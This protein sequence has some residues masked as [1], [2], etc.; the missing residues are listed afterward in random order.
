MNFVDTK[1]V[2]YALVA[3]AFTD[4]AMEPQR[5]VNPGVLATARQ[6]A[7]EAA[8]GRGT[9]ENYLALLPRELHTE[10]TGFVNQEL[11]G[12][13]PTEL[14]I[15]V[16]EYLNGKIVQDLSKEEKK[17]LIRFIIHSFPRSGNFIPT[18]IV[19]SHILQ[20]ENFKELANDPDEIKK[21]HDIINQYQRGRGS[22]EN[23]YVIFALLNTEGAF[24]YLKN[25]YF[26]NSSQKWDM[27]REL[28]E[29]MKSWYFPY[30]NDI[31]Y[32]TAQILLKAGVSA[33]ATPYVPSKEY[34]NLKI[35]PLLTAIENKAPYETVKLLIDYHADV[36][37]R[38]SLPDLP[39]ISPLSLAHKK[40]NLDPRIIPLLL[41]HGATLEGHD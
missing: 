8:H 11:L 37:Q 10:L 35:T 26:P 33:N 41:E 7:Q 38:G 13:L 32:K 15:K 21:I 16:R 19:I 28:I 4:N 31:K 22:W 14:Q 25:A 34:S 23:N 20:L 17:D 1:K 40:Q 12:L 9:I 18:T 24:T 27:E 30:H 2:I 29:C 3:T 39:A 36:N 5:R 6:S